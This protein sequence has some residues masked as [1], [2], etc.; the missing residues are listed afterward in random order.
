MCAPKGL[1]AIGV[2]EFEHWIVSSRA[3][4]F[5]QH[6]ILERSGASPLSETGQEHVIFRL[7]FSTAYLRMMVKPPKIMV[8]CLKLRHFRSKF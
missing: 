3:V 4:V 1:V 5:Q 2:L 8:T 7:Q 6:T